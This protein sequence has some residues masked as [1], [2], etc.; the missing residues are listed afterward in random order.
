MIKTRL[1]GLVPDSKRFI[2]ANVIAQWIG[3]C[4][5]AFMIFT[6]AGML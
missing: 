5:N 3:L 4:S 1:I 2:A 6:I